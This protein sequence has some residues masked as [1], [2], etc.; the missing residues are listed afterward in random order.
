MVRTDKPTDM[1]QCRVEAVFDDWDG[2]VVNLW[3]RPRTRHRIGPPYCNKPD[4]VTFANIL[5][6]DLS[7]PV[8]VLEKK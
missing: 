5:A 7:F 6:H 1:F 2:W 3:V 4:A 8:R